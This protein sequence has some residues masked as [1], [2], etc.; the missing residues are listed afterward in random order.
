MRLAILWVGIAAFVWIGLHPPMAEWSSAGCRWPAQAPPQWTEHRV[1]TGCLLGR[2]AA[3]VALTGGL[4]W[5]EAQVGPWVWA[6]PR[7]V[8]SVAAV[9]LLLF[10]LAAAV[11]LPPWGLLR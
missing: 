6:K 9:G 3:V 5:T 8:L 10:G 7:A 4:L 11:L 2:L 1:D